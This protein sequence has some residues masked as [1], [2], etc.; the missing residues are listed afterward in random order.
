MIETGTEILVI[1][2]GKSGLA[3][4]ETA[5]NKGATVWVYEDD[6]EKLE[7]ALNSRDLKRFDEE[8][9]ADINFVVTSPGIPF[10]HR[11]IRKAGENKW[12]VLSEIE[13]AYNLLKP[14]FVIGVTGTNGKT[15]VVEMLENI[16]KLSGKPYT[17][18]GN[19]GKPLSSLEK[20]EGP[21]ILE[22]SSF[23][24]HFTDRFRAN[25]AAVL[26]ITDDHND[27]HCCFGQYLEDKLKIFSNQE[28]D[29]LV[30]VNFDEQAL[31]GVK[32][33][34]NAIGFG[35][36]DAAAY[37]LNGE[38]LKAYGE[39][40]IA[41]D[42]IRLRGRHNYL[43]ALAAMACAKEAGLDWPVIKKGITSFEGLKHRLQHITEKNDVHFYN[44]SKST[45]PDSTKKAIEAFKQPV[46]LI[47]GGRNKGNKFSF[48]REYL[49]TRIKELI[50]YGEAAEEISKQAGD[51]QITKTVEQA[52]AKAFNNAT[53]GD[54]I[55]FSPGCSSFD[56]FSDYAQRGDAFIQAVNEING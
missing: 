50:I 35:V 56:L 52:L 37:R 16:F 49:G 6:K 4:A 40:I 5:I 51:A 12:P 9:S 17:V 1:G 39:N 15:T 36:D 53:A 48:L 8:S 33:K 34:E 10:N 27:W 20:V 47:M 18:A 45:N 25:I 38:Y 46:V 29:D 55:L 14:K 24:L 31:K 7:H 43:N 28:S 2:L 22:L 13:F 41:V 3:V 19:I 54:I 42:E 23:Q 11:L 44:D 26:N 21:L 30:L 32:E